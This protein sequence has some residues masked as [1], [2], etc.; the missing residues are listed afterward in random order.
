MDPQVR[1]AIEADALEQQA[2]LASVAVP[3]ER[4]WRPWAIGGLVLLILA[5][6]AVIAVIAGRLV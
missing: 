4:R 5:L 3:R 1:R 2:R 6:L